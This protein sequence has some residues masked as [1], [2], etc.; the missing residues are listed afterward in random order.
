MVLSLDSSCIAEV[1]MVISHAPEMNHLL[2]ALPASVRSR[3]FTSLKLVELELGEVIY[4]AGQPLEFVYFPINCI[5]SLVHEMFDGASAG[6]SIVGCEG[7]VGVAVFMDAESTLSR[8]VVQSKGFAYRMS[9]SKLQ[10][11]FNADVDIR[12]LMLRFT[13]A[14]IAQMSQTAVCNRH[15]SIIQQLCRWLLLSLDRLSGSSL[16]VTQELIAKMLGVRRES[17]T[18]AAGKLQKLKVIECHRGQIIVIDRLELE[19]LCCECYALVKHETDRL[20]GYASLNSV[21]KT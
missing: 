1:G 7:M 6:I 4:E 18:E 16:K 11:E 5:I 21:H 20:S 9:S 2:A 10:E 12:V 15:H 14:L 17:V 3:F 8:A 13:Q 19:T